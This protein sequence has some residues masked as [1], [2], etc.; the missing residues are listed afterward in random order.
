MTKHI[1]KLLTLIIILLSV[2]SCA[3]DD[4]YYSQ[5]YTIQDNAW[6]YADSL[7]FTPE[8]KDS[9]IKCD[10]LLSVRHDNKF[11]YSNLWLELST[12]LND[13]VMRRDTIN[14]RL[15]DVYGT[16]LG[17]GAAVSYNYT[18]TVFRNLTVVRGRPFIIKHIMR[19]DTVRNIE[20]VGLIFEP[21]Q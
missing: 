12:P 2:A 5:F 21:K 20:R 19:P 11:R 16:W 13:S 9:I 15:A 6:Y 17:K 18:D 14:V 3:P 10:V 8:P 1:A 7:V 4:N